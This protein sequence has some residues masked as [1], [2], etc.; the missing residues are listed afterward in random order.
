MLTFEIVGTYISKHLENILC[1][2]SLQ[3]FQI[4]T[5]K[6]IVLNQMTMTQDLYT[7]HEYYFQNHLRFI[8]FITITI[9][10]HIIHL[11]RQNPYITVII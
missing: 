2:S 1:N 4:K 11:Y 8:H 9:D 5:K 10:F 6:D 3:K 7:N